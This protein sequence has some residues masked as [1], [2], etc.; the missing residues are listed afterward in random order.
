M[1]A[2]IVGA[3]GLVGRELVAQLQQDARFSAVHVMVRRLD[4][5]F[6]AAGQSK[7][8][9]HQVDFEHIAQ[10]DW[11]SCNA[12]FCALGTTIKSAGS[13]DAFRQVDVD[14]VVACAKR[15]RQSGATQLAVVSALGASVK[16]GTFYSR[17]K[18]EME[19]AVASLGYHGVT[20]VRP[21][22][23][24][25]QRREHRPGERFMLAV[26]QVGNHFLPKRYRSVQ[27]AAV[28]HCL[29]AAVAENRQGVTLIES[30]QISSR[31]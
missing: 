2:C 3:T 31:C 1:I 5:A 25:G 8:T 9:Q 22:F 28:A 24:A 20:I 26:M 4:A 11:P 15:A 16:S 21:S 19:G 12:L 6:S 29:R 14:Y 18:G 10:T 27:A 17:V 7:I 13:Q 23:L 30:D